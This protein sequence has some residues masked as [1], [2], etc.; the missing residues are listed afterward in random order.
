MKWPK[1]GTARNVQPKR[2]LPRF[3][4]RFEALEGRWVPAL[5]TNNLN[6]D[7]GAHA[8][9]HS[10]AAGS[11]NGASVVVVEDHFSAS[12]TDV[13]ARLVRADG[14]TSVLFPATST[15]NEHDPAVAMDRNGNFVVVWTEDVNS[16]F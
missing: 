8:Q 12:D 2:S 11:T 13:S 4:P 15:A 16:L 14:T 3:R 9:D 6:L 10:A 7:F 5:V 1:F